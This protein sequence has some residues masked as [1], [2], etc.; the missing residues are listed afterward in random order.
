MANRPFRDLRL[1]LS[2]EPQAPLFPNA[3]AERRIKDRPRTALECEVV[4]GQWRERHAGTVRNIHEGGARVRISCRPEDVTEPVELRV[5]GRVYPAAVAWRSER[6]VGLR[7]IAALD[8][9]AERQVADLR[10]ILEQMR[11]SAHR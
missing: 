8:D 11:A 1:P 2:A 6:E 10:S 4:H 5:G 9:D 7:F 3:A